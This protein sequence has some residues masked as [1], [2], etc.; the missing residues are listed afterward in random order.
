LSFRR[1]L[2]IG[3][4][5]Y[6]R[7]NE[8]PPLAAREEASNRHGRQNDR[9]VIATEPTVDIS[10]REIANRRATSWDGMAAEIVQTTRRARID[11]RFSAPVHLLVVVEQGV[12]LADETLVEGLPQS[13]LKNL[14]RKLTFA[15]AGHHYQNGR[16]PPCFLEPLI[17]ISILR[18]C[19][20][21]SKRRTRLR[22]AHPACSSRIQ[23]LW[24]TALKLRRLMESPGANIRLC[25]EALGVIL[26]HELVRPPQSKAPARGG[27]AAWQQ[28]ILLDYIEENL[29]EQIPLATLAQLSS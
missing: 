7:S 17:S 16:S 22:Y 25:F 4:I 21:I 13:T 20:S 12:R 10:P 11:I 3:A 23:R 8:P 9:T 19:R 5:G 28:R 24:E 2:R 29:A 14:R 1:Y 6:I 26:M 18:P 27:L 15:P